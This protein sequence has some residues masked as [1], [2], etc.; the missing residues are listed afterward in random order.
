MSD[1]PAIL[2]AEAQVQAAR[3]QLFRTLGEVQERLSPSHLAQD[4]VDSASQGIASV[5]RKGR[6]AVRTRPAATAAVAGAVGL[7]LARGWIAGLFKHRPDETA[8][9]PNG[10]TDNATS[11]EK[12]GQKGL[13]S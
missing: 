12:T 6:D 13:S 1:D 11:P 7:V 4:A 3:A 5:A 2:A 8:S 10:L 9:E